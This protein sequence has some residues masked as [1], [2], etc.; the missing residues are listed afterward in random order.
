ME[1][2]RKQNETTV[3]AELVVSDRLPPLDEEENALGSNHHNRQFAHGF[4]GDQ[5]DGEAHF[6]DK[7]GVNIQRVNKDKVRCVSVVDHPY[8]YR[9]LAFMRVTFEAAGIEVQL[10]PYTVVIPYEEPVE[11]EPVA[12]GME[13]V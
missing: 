8:C 12:V 11:E 7:I 6:F 9:S 2:L 10:D 4:M 5:R 1:E 13:V 3:I